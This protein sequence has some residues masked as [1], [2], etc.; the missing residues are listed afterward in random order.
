[1]GLALANLPAPV[2]VASYI[3]PHWSF[4]LRNMALAV[5]LTRAGL[6]LDAEVHT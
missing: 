6:E 1:M 5:I 3:D 4:T 2:N